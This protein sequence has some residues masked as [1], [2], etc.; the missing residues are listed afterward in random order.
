MI[1]IRDLFESLCQKIDIHD[2][3]HLSSVEA[4]GGI[5]YDQMSMKEFVEFHHGGETALCTVAIW[6][7]AMLGVEPGEVSALW[8]LHY[9]KAGGGLMQMR[10]DRMGGGQF[11]RIKEGSPH[12]RAIVGME[13]KLIT[14]GTQAF[15]TGLADLLPSDSI[16][17][18]APVKAV[19][20]CGTSVAVSTDNKTYRAKRVVISLPTVLYKTIQFVPPLPDFKT[21][22]ATK[23][24]HGHYSKVFLSYAT[25]W[26][27]DLESISSC[28]LTQSL[29]GLVAVTRDTSNDKRRHFSLICFVV[30]DPG[31]RWSILSAT[32]RRAAVEEHIKSIY[33]PLLDMKCKG[34]KVP[35]LKSY[36]EQNW[37]NE[38]FSGG[39]PCPA[40]P[41]GLMSEVGGEIRSGVGNLS[42]VGTETA[43]EWRGYME[44][45]VRSGERG[46]KEVIESLKSETA[47]L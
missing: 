38:V 2:P 35:G 29:K 16:I 20:D 3:D 27:R 36:T 40:F 45:A 15:S 22:L 5:D 1:R 44:G 4:L 12:S 28:G 24:V 37:N 30:G 23:T 6:T 43:F 47:R 19:D 17:L 39:C 32:E 21:S 9:C 34:R 7:R 25:P 11:L 8:F 42:F 13:R 18:N 26:W 41:P 31:R 33:Q 14:T 10:S 46:A